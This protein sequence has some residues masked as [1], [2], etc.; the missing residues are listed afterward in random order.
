MSFVFSLKSVSKF[1]GDDTLFQDLSIDY[2]AK[3]QMGLIGVNGSGK[4]TLLK[5]VAGQALPDE[6]ELIRQTQ[7]NF[8]YLPQ[9]DRFPGDATVEQVLRDSVKTRALEEK[10]VHRIVSR[11]MGKGG[12][13]QPSVKVET[14]S[15]GWKKKLAICRALCQEPDLLLLDEPTNHLDING[16]LWLESILKAA[17]F[18]FILVSHDRAFLEA[19]CANM[20]EIGMHFPGGYFKVKGQ[21]KHF[22]RERGK[23]LVAQEKQQASLTSR[24]R[25]EDQ[26]LRQGAKARTTKAKYRIDQAEVL[27]R[28]LTAVKQRNRNAATVDIDFNATG[29]KTKKLLRAFNL[30]KSIQGRPLF[31]NLT[32]ELGP[33]F[34]LGVA[35]ENGSGKST[36]LSILERQMRPDS[37]KVEWAPDLKL[38]VFDQTRSRLDP[39]ATL[40]DALNP[41]GGDSIHYKGRSLHIVSWAKRFLF[42]PDQLD[43]PVKRLSGGEKARILIANIMMTPCDVLLLDEPTNDLDILSLEVLEESLLNFP[44]AVVIVSHDRYLMDKVCHRILYLDPGNDALF[45]RDFSQILEHRRKK[46]AAASKPRKKPREKKAAS[47]QFSFKDKYELEHIEEKIMAKEERAEDLSGLITLPEIVTDAPKMKAYCSELKELQER[48]QELYDRWQELEM[49]KEAAGK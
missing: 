18:S 34:R 12:F 21:Y 41:A 29:R 9:E 36:F 24:M 20:L 40:R 3:E 25:R 6:G 27:R 28:E 15:G 13:T 7:Q 11:S 1:Y 38:A 33:G 14:L 17:R 30:E 37:G 19:V 10:E 31:S 39:E 35:G 42:M 23:F 45:F 2:T 32:F 43:M 22:I 4:S 46:E 16:I 8:V 44:G 48:I 47:V 5:L 26:W 49:L